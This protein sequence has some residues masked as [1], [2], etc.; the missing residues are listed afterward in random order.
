MQSDVR[1]LVGSNVRRCRLAVG[2]TQAELAA[3][4]D[5]DRAYVS[6]LER[7]ERNIT[8]ISLWHT[9]VALGVTMVD[10]VTDRGGAP[11]DD[12]PVKRRSRD[13]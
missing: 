10:L 12:A 5:V 7:G 4:M 11:P 13:D 1:H 2:M 8:I 9:A 6:G 3:R